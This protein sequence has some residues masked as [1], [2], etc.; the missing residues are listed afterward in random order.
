[1]AERNHVMINFRLNLLKKSDREIHDYLK[2]FDTP[3]FKA[4]LKSSKSNFI[5]NVLLDRKSVV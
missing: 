1:M 2:Q 3:E 5:K 4:I